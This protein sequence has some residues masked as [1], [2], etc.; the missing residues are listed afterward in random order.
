MSGDAAQPGSPGVK[1]FS[2]GVHDVW[3]RLNFNLNSTGNAGWPLFPAVTLLIAAAHLGLFAYFG[4]QSRVLRPYSDMFDLIGFYFQSQ[5]DGNWLHYLLE[6]HNYH[7]LIWYRL[8]LALDV[9]LKGTGLPFVVVALACMTGIA[10]MLTRQVA[11]TG[12]ERMKLPG[13]VFI[14]M[15]VLS[16]SNSVDLSVP[17]NTPYVHT[18]LFAV[19]AILLAQRR[20]VDGGPVGRARLAALACACG[21]A[22]SNAVGLVLWPALAFL[23]WRAGKSERPWL[24]TI[25]ATGG[26]FATAYV[27]DQASHGGET[28]LTVE[29]LVKMADYFF[30]YLGLPWSRAHASGGRLVGM[31]LFGLALIALFRKGG[32]GATKAERVALGLIL[33]SLGTALLAALGR[34]DIAESVIAPGRYSLLVTPL[35]VG[36]VLLAL[37]A[38]ERTWLARPRV[39]ET[40]LLALFAVY[41]F[42]QAAIGE[43]V[44]EKQR[45]VRAT[46]TQF[47][48]GVRTEQMTLL[49]HPDLAHAEA[50]CQEMRSRGLYH[51][52]F[53]PK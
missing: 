40:C 33:F 16:T 4:Y 42:K 6:P 29:S 14:L 21:A 47:H 41:L 11:A 53:I 39:V 17:A 45:V 51:H 37:P 23:A 13:M 18:L 38:L 34:R 32:E 43:V 30:N 36:L 5:D 27:W 50:L 3:T 22:F 2:D 1:T 46:I 7:R 25:L 9:A 28:A 10:V 24:I 49:I 44:A 26:A 20:A 31:M 48:E 52:A 12:V 15:L 8:L 35:K 19:A